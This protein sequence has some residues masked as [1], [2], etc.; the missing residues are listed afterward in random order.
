MSDRQKP[1]T[2]QPGTLQ[3]STLQPSTLPDRYFDDVYAA[4]DDPWSFETSPYEAAKYE[5]TLLALTRDRYGSALE[6]GCSI[7]VF[8]A[9]LAQRCDRLLALDVSQQALERARARCADLS[10]THFE[11]RRLPQQFPAGQFDLIVASE[12]L[13]Y[14][15]H[16]D[17]QATLERC[18]AALPAGGELLCVHWTPQVHDY[19]QTGDEV[20][21][22]VFALPGLIAVHAERHAQYRLD[23]FRRS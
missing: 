22:A 9:R 11:R 2:L 8:S 1:G 14:L 4:H 5:R 15:G 6:I 7:G 19:P 21:A 16:S 3:P 17:L 10:Q 13:Y 23:L 18:L 20:H 12:V